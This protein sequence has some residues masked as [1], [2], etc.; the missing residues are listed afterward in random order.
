MRCVRAAYTLVP[1]DGRRS[2]YG[3]GAVLGA[4]ESLGEASYPDVRWPHRELPLADVLAGVARERRL[5]VVLWSFFSTEFGAAQHRLAAIRAGTPQDAAVLHVVGGAHASAEPELTLRAGWDLVAHGEGEHT[6]RDLVRTLGGRA[7][8]CSPVA[9]RH[10]GARR[11]RSGG[12][13]GLLARG[14]AV[15]PRR[16][17]QRGEPQGDRRGAHRVGPGR[18]RRR[19]APG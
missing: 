13:G 1:A 14:P 8:D 2:R 17:R 15:L 6:I 19:G 4:L 16:R 11:R 7:A 3:I 10:D 18:A 5:A 12:D 9:L